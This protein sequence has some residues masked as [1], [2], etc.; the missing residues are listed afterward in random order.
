MSNS[1]KRFNKNNYEKKV[2]TNK[3]SPL[4]VEKI[5]YISN[6]RGISNI[7]SKNLKKVIKGLSEEKKNKNKKGQKKKNMSIN[8]NQNSKELKVKNVNFYHHPDYNK[9]DIINT[10]LVK[11]LKNIVIQKSI[12]KNELNKYKKIEENLGFKHKKKNILKRQKNYEAIKSELCHNNNNNLNNTFKNI[13][14]DA[15]FDNQNYNR[16]VRNSSQ[17]R[18]K[19]I[20]NF[21]NE[22][23][24]NKKNLSSNFN[25]KVNSRYTNL[26]N[27]K[28]INNSLSISKDKNLEK[29]K[30]IGNQNRMKKHN[31]SFNINE[32]NKS[33]NI[34]KKIYISES[35]INM[36]IK[37][38]SS[39]KKI[40]HKKIVIHSE[41]KRYDTKNKVRH[42]N[43]KFLSTH[44]NSRSNL[45]LDVNENNDLLNELYMKNKK[46]MKSEENLEKD[47]NRIFNESIIKNKPDI[48][49]E[50]T[51]KK[52]EK[53][54]K[55][56][57]IFKIEKLCKKG[58]NGEIKDKPNQDNYF[59]YSNFNNNSS[60]I[61]MGVCDGHGE[62]GHEISSF[63]VTNLPLVLGN[64]FRVFN[65]KDISVI[66]YS[67]ILTIISN[68]FKQ[69]N[70]NLS[71][72]NN[73]DCSFSGSTC[74]SL[75]YTPKKVF[76][77]NL[78]DSRCI[79]G[80]YDGK[81]WESKNLSNDHKPDSVVEKERIIKSGGIV[82][83]MIDEGG[84]FIGPQRVWV[85]DSNL[86]GLA[87][88]RS[89]GDEV[90]H[91][92]GV[93]C[94]PEIIEYEL[95]EEDKFIIMASDGIWEFISSQECV[96]IV[97]DYYNNDNCKGAV[98][99]LYK[100]SCKK[101]LEE[102]DSIDDITLIIVFFK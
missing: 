78:G 11:K 44:L 23:F 93:S 63:L 6:N 20:T 88:S 50:L 59:I 2:L 33:K 38:N 4:S 10:V 46:I 49:F 102:E 99:H 67:T 71:L 91:Q 51:Q 101:W 56:K 72:E 39:I 12:L 16:T 45:K 100:E 85:K 60:H 81:N 17:K 86:P 89:F 70:K 82:R 54:I 42:K 37:K 48:S 92:I 34:N 25:C 76:C 35:N 19:I 73:I 9:K 58:Y 94:E 75:L 55:E 26:K 24:Y 61:Y 22:L 7:N 41:G 90:A 21:I 15:I 18:K 80:K 52:D 96:N 53:I 28:L 69:I 95:L 5:N 8:F 62:Y 84:E 3:N 29:R 64:F 57:K 87:M 65:I 66:D 97:K 47:N 68:S 30:F 83:P 77:I 43:E 27:N 13:T 79:I 36:L 31:I 98:K 1:E 32:L 74:I 14:I 40:K